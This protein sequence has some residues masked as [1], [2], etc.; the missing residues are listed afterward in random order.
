MPGRMNSEAMSLQKEKI[1]KETKR[2][3]MKANTW[4]EGAA[5]L[6]IWGMESMIFASGFCDCER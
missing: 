6:S 5:H 3:P 1:F 2:M 4:V